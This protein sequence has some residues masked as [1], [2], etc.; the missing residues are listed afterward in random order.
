MKIAKIMPPY[1]SKTRDSPTKYRPI[2]LLLTISK[3]LEKIIYKRLFSFL[4]K[5]TVLYNNQYRFRKGHSCQLAI[6]ELVGEISQ[7]RE[8]KEAYIKCLP[9]LV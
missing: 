3:L 1:K 2:S 9:R 6:T 4:E 5:N 7:S 8:Q